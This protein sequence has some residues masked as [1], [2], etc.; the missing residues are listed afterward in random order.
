[1]TTPSTT[2]IAKADKLPPVPQGVRDKIICMLIS[3]EYPTDADIARATGVSATYITKLLQSDPELAEK[4]RE[5]EREVAQLIEKSAIE[6]AQRGRNEMAKQRSQEFLLKKMYADKYG[7]N[8]EK[9]NSEKGS[10]KVIIKLKMEEVQ[11]D[12]NGI[13]IAQ[14][15]NPLQDVID[16]Q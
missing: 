2:A 10:R 15:A 8:A 3:G 1:M 11:T 14:S 6:L 13:P 9:V 5:A 16:V 7:D 4:R 12:A